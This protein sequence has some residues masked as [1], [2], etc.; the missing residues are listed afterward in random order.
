MVGG[1]FVRGRRLPQD[2]L[3]FSSPT[4]RPRRS[5]RTHPADRPPPRLRAWI[6]LPVPP[7][8]SCCARWATASCR[9]RS[10]RAPPP[11]PTSGRSSTCCARPPW[12]WAT[13]RPRSSTSRPRTG[14]RRAWSTTGACPR[15]QAWRPIS[16]SWG[17]TSWRARTTTRWTGDRARSGS[18]RSS[19]TRRRRLSCASRSRLKARAGL[20]AP[21]PN[22]WC[23]NGSTSD[24]IFRRKRR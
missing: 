14:S 15:R 20:R 10:R 23:R 8:G 13:S 6:E 24:R 11:T 16:P 7:T 12:R 4:T 19:S 1:D 22:S 3:R 18:A 9:S 2:V 21:A 5:S 17:S